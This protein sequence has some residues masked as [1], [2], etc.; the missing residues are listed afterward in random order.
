MSSDQMP[1]PGED[2]ARTT[3]GK[4]ES[5]VSKNIIYTCDIC[6]LYKIDMGGQFG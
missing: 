5:N 3:D 4:K 1:R 2:L 6:F